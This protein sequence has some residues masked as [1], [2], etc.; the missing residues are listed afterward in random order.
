MIR[1]ISAALSLLLLVCLVI[2][3]DNHFFGRTLQPKPAFAQDALVLEN[4]VLYSH[5]EIKFDNI[6]E[7]RGDV[8]SNGSIDIK[9]GA[10]GSVIGSFQ[11][12]GD[13]K[14]EAE[15]GIYGDVT[16]RIIEDK[17][18]LSVAG[19]KIERAD[20]IPLTLPALLFSSTGPDLQVPAT[21]SRAIAPGS[22]GRLKVKKG[23]AVNLSSGE[24][25]FVKFELDDFATVNLDVSGGAIEINVTDKIKF[26]NNV[27]MTIAGGH[28]NSV[29]FNY[30][31]T[32][33]VK[34]EDH[35]VLR[36]ILTAPS[37][38][39]E[40]KNGSRLEG[41]AYA[42]SIQ[43]AKGASFRHYAASTG[44]RPPTAEA[45][46]YQ[47]A[48][49]GGQV[50]LDGSG[51]SDPDGDAITYRWAFVSF[52]EGSSPALSDPS[53]PMPNFT[54]D[55]VGV[56]VIELSVDD[57]THTSLK[58]T[59]T[60][61]A[62]SEVLDVT[63][64]V[65]YADDKI[66]MDEISGGVG[67]VGVNRHIHIEK[68][69]SGTIA[70]DLRVLGH[71]KND[72]EITITGDVITNSQIDDR[73][74]MTVTGVKV[75][76]ATLAPRML[77]PVSFTAE[78]PDLQ[79][80][81]SAFQALDPGAYGRVEVKRGA[82]LQFTAG[83]YFLRELKTDDAAILIF[84][85]SED[86]SELN[87]AKK[88]E[89]GKDADLRII[90]GSTRAVLINYAGKKD[91]EIEDR[92]ILRGTLVAPRA[93][94]ELEKGSRLEGAVYARKIYLDPGV[95]FQF[96]EPLAASTP[97]V[98]ESQTIT[99]AEDAAASITLSGSDPDGDSLT[100]AVSSQPQNGI[101]A[102]A[103][104]NLIYTPDANFN[105]KDEFSFTVNDGML[106]S[107]PATVNI[108]VTAVNDAPVAEAGSDQSV[109]VTDRVSLNGD[110]SN[111]VDNDSLSYQWFFS[112]VPTGS[113]AALSD[114]SIANPDF[115]PDIAGTYAVQLIVNDGAVDSATDSVV[116]TAD[117]APFSAVQTKMTARSEE[118]NR[119][120][121]T[122]VAIDGD[123][124]IAGTGSAYIYQYDGSAWVEQAKLTILDEESGDHFGA[125]VAISTDTAL[126]GAYGQ[127]DAGDGSGAA[128]IF[129]R[130]V[131]P[132]GTEQWTEKTKLT[133]ADAAAGD[134][135]GGAV[136]IG[137]DRAL[138]GAAGDDDNGADSGS[139]YVFAFDGAAW[140]QQ[141]KLTAT[142]AAAGDG[143]GV[144]TSMSADGVMVGAAGDDDSG[145]DA[146][147]AYFFKLE[148]S[149]WQQQDKLIAADG[150]PGDGFGMSLAVSG[151]D[152]I[153]GAAGVDGRGA[154]AGA[155]YIF[156]F[157]G[158]AWVQQSKLT[159][160]DAQPGD[161]FGSSV[162]IDGTYAVVGAPGDDDSGQD[163]GAVYIFKFDGSAWMEIAKFTPEAAHD[164]DHFGEAVAI[165]GANVFAGAA[166]D[167][168]DGADS[169]AAYVF[170]IESYYSVNLT[171]EPAIIEPGASADLSW[172]SVNATAARLD[173]GIGAV[174][175][176]GFRTV[177]PTETT[178]YTLTTIGPYGL[179]TASATV[180]LNQPPS[181]TVVAPDGIG[182]TADTG[183]TIQWIDAD[184]DDDATVSLYYDTDNSGADGTLIVG[185]LSEDPDGEGH[186]DYVWETSHLP[187]GRYYI[188]AVIDDGV[189][190]P[191]VDYSE[192]VV[193]VDH[194][195]YH[196]IKLN[197]VD[198]G[199]D[200]GDYFGDVVFISGDVAIVGSEADDD[201]SDFSGSAYIFQREGDRWR[202]Q[203]KLTAGD[204]RAHQ[205]FG[206]S[207]SVS[208][209]FAVVGAWNDD[210]EGAESGSAYI[211]E[212]EGSVWTQKSKLKASDS[213]EK[214]RFGTSV[215]IGGDY[216]I[217]GAWLD[218]DDGSGSGS[219]YI[220]RRQVLPDGSAQWIE[221][222]KLTASDADVYDNFGICL[223]MS[224]DYVAVGA[225][226]DD[227]GGSNSGSAYVFRREVLPDGT[228][229]WTETAKLTAGDAAEN[230]GFGE[231]IAISGDYAIVGAS[232]NDDGGSGSGAAYIFKR[233]ELP[234]GTE[235][236]TE[237][238]KLVAPDA[239][240]W[241]FFGFSVSLSGDLAIVGAGSNDD[242]GSSSGS[243][244]I[245][246][247]EG[248]SWT[249]QTKLTASDAAA[250]DYFGRSVSIS[251]GYAIIGSYGD[252]DSGVDAGS[253]Y[254]YALPFPIANIGADPAIIAVESSA[255]LSWSS[256]NANMV[257]IE[258][259]I[260]S[261]NVIGSITV[262][263]TE[264]T[265]YTIKADS[266]L[267]TAADSVTITVYD[268]SDPV[269]ATITAEPETL[270][271]GQ[272][273]T[274]TWN[275]TNAISCVIEPDIGPVDL[276]GS[277][278]VSPATT[279]TYIITATGPVGTARDSVE[280]RVNSAPENVNYGLDT[281]ERQGGGGLAGESVRVS[282]GN[283]VEVRSDLQFPSPN[284]LG[285]GLDAVYNSRS[286]S[287]G[288]M[289]YGWT[290][291]YEASLDP[292]VEIEGVT[293]LKIIEGS[294][295]ASY[296]RPGP[297]S[298]QYVG[299]FG[300]HSHVR[301]EP[302]GYGWYRLD[303]S[304]YFFSSSGRL[305]RMQDAVGNRIDLAYD[306]SNRLNTVSDAAS[307]RILTLRYNGNGLLDYIS[308]PITYAV[309]DGRW[310]A[311]GYD[312]DLN[313]TSVTYA[314]D[315][316][317]DYAYTDT[318]DVHNLTEKRDRLDHLLN[319]WDYDDQ[320]R[321]ISTFSR[322]G[323]GVSIVYA[324]SDQVNVTDAYGKERQ[325]HLDHIA[326]RRRVIAIT[327]T[328][329]GGPGAI[330]YSA[331][332]AVSWTYDDE[333]RLIE[334]ES[335]AGTITRYLDYD[336][337]GNP[338][339]VTSAFGT[340]QERTVAYVYHPDMDAPLSRTEASVLGA[341]AKETIWDYDDPGAAG[342]TATPN[343]SPTRRLYR[344]IE[345]GYTTD[346]A[347]AVI[348]YEYI[349]TYS[350][351]GKGQVLSIDGPLPGSADTTTFAY[352][353]ET[354][355]LLTMA[356]PLIGDTTFADYDAAGQVGRT[357]DVNDLQTSFDYDGRGRV[358]TVVHP[359]ARS[360]TTTYTLAGQVA[361]RID[362]DNVATTYTYDATYGRLWKI[363]DQ[364]GNEI[365][366]LYDL[367]GNLIEKA[368]RDD[369]GT[370]SNRLRWDYQHPQLPGMLY[371]EI[372]PDGTFTRYDYDFN[373][374]VASV[375]DP[376]GHTT[377]YFYDALN[378]REE[379]RQPEPEPG[380]G[381]PITEYDYDGHGNLAAVV[382]ANQAVT[383]FQYDDMDRQ[384]FTVSPDSGSG[385]FAYDAA[386][387]RVNKMDAMGINVRYTYDILDR[388]QMIDFPADPDI[389]YT[390]DQ[391][392][393]A[394]GRLTGVNDPSGSTEFGYD[395]RGRL[396]EKN[397]TV[398]GVDYLLSRSYS[399]GGR[400]N[401]VT[402]PTGRTIDFF[403]ADCACRVDAIYSNY[404]DE[405]VTLM[406]NLTYLPFGGATGM[407]TGAG[408]S[409]RNVTDAAGRLRVANPG[410]RTERTFEYFPDGNLKS[411]LVSN[412][413]GKNRT[414]QYDALNRLTN[415]D[416]PYGAFQ[417][418]YQYDKVG[419]RL[420]K[421]TRT[422]KKETDYFY[423]AGTNQLY[424]QYAAGDLILF[425]Y[426]PNGNMS[427][428]GDKTLVYNQDNRLV[429]V[430]GSQGTLG[431]YVY[432][433]L[434]QRVIKAAD[435]LTTVF[436]YDFEG[437]II[438]ESD[439]GG[440]FTR[441]YLYR[442]RNRVLMVDVASQAVYTYLNDRLGTP[443]AI[444]DAA[445]N[446]VWEATYRPFGEPRVHP[447]ATL[448]NNFRFLGQYYDEETGLY[449]NYHR[450]YDPRTGR[451]LTPDPIG[452]AGGI[453][454]YS[455]VHNNP[456]NWADPQGL[457][458]IVTGI[459]EE[460]E[461]EEGIFNVLGRWFI[462]GPLGLCTLFPE[463]CQT[464]VEC[465]PPAGGLRG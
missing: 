405:R 449:Y 116:I 26:K 392:P 195:S 181:I 346:T 174:P 376:E 257:F 165:D 455:Y 351:N 331:S 112:S 299:V 408:G 13:I 363:T 142:D 254:I 323:T 18:S 159:A 191:V 311:Y 67:H 314:D 268:P 380:A 401:T 305:L 11:A 464:E 432:N 274:L 414:Y 266:N 416:D 267:G 307:G 126:V 259:E 161:A 166:G 58:D 412:E 145:A 287:L 217:V 149:V 356:R 54:A 288:S 352:D 418:R 276:T 151:S 390:Y 69:P 23:A 92:C 427:G 229:H 326:G 164:G 240:P 289:G 231:S 75:E 358:K 120:F 21:S 199:A 232:G 185:N 399:P 140:S 273:S 444:T 409:V 279:T 211:F 291:T 179:Q 70:G 64:F 282:N 133:A 175:V 286:E 100:F 196:E 441:E 187:G 249:F 336:E 283:V 446:A 127:D 382:D 278:E 406:E 329:P 431:E 316:G 222:A 453:N 37:A 404:G 214:D 359:D 317:F 348:P 48:L 128:Y 369:L 160:G 138:V 244:Y 440:T 302:G 251:G 426:D 347:E 90:K 332:N 24:Y 345:T 98:A 36:G 245:F 208:G 372:N 41:A 344:V 171:A 443:I 371:E 233:E 435:G 384:V 35:A 318:G 95:S 237:Q 321:A 374:N 310:V 298:G 322:K 17:G 357:I 139:A 456:I 423:L 170:T 239:A 313:L 306:A 173:Q 304:K 375:T 86:V 114:S 118:F 10:T 34:V 367:Q 136:A 144:S 349:T 434:G 79:V 43:L 77:P 109:F 7:S 429:R 146:G 252:D 135:F 25:Y 27:D 62:V 186:D 235:Q 52:P 193:V 169:G 327:S 3:L 1:K 221:T 442:G 209:E 192:G 28:S 81:E 123:T 183:F 78:G 410:E 212:R 420:G 190:E 76:N 91:V 261:V 454:L 22:Y 436:H 242:S 182:D 130:E 303:G 224:G 248:S 30:R 301:A 340:A 72:G 285:L 207:V 68:G 415:V 394:K 447:M 210:D 377:F 402:Y 50:E 143:F 411:V 270:F 147:A 4:F 158:L 312:A 397:S 421:T 445:G 398:N 417:Y 88:L 328:H 111:D 309:D 150:A 272:D 32:D 189:N 194:T 204:P 430:D 80:P 121:G 362:E 338:G 176:T 180:F 386:G 241:D 44:G 29:L 465:S 134:N 105:G 379:M 49:A 393:Y 8:G 129:E 218:D 87:V 155:A 188:Y 236:W 370:L 203:A 424:F 462:Y 220:F 59:A 198:V 297:S 360:E 202:Q 213:A 12:L 335:A 124:A 437:N 152:A 42:D 366:H 353:P 230:D 168:D 83:S 201:Y 292:A 247:R 262:S 108:T 354:G 122:A 342:D 219:A 308:G 293:T 315:S 110:A 94:V 389:S 300:E 265:T 339:T 89:F 66:K 324:G 457:F 246:K 162:A 320:G 439:P 383:T 381:I 163:A 334:T 104:P 63:D 184:P 99:T 216:A 343:E 33:K 65:L 132:D 53:V 167:D 200:Q 45:G 396:V 403:R 385:S 460:G 74:T 103:V 115:V 461:V 154:D 107:E 15:I 16:A 71:I 9:K 40:F 6:G 448:A 137:Q 225:E 38:E 205:Y 234:D 57:G 223:A 413:N 243:A 206:S 84:D 101:I 373:G 281:N 364:E 153:V 387:R 55:Q 156:K 463:K 290:H 271:P 177:S 341:G 215:A 395:E 131:L 256:T 451:Y 438:G 250:S 106:D 450:Y 428:M 425:T 419:N 226:G 275:S 47:T 368:Y 31:G 172:T 365:E 157:D 452:L 258:P 378:R 113:T 280:V 39:V 295:R 125:A 102:G 2:P 46:G 325:Y 433:A 253:A 333:L 422:Q 82:T 284:R 355:D 277:L 96:H 255:T 260:G 294:G 141:A 5:R 117:Y 60:I 19:Q 264:T 20:L 51:S 319:S 228:E 459:N 85:V 458:K 388:L 197:A 178:T 269:V 227:D 263:P 296:F 337:R 119:G 148:N 238:A 350:Y 361:T 56:Y 73:G 61:T 93:R 97:P 391:G 400:V 407:D 14:N 330:P